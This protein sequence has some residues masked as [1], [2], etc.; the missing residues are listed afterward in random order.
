MIPNITRGDRFAGLVSYL[1]GKGRA[2]EHTDPRVIAGES[3]LFMHYAGRTL[4]AQDALDLGRDLEE[5]RRVTGTNVRRLKRTTSVDARTGVQVLEATY[6]DAHVWHCSLSLAAEEGQLSDEQWN[7]IASDFVDAMG[8]TSASGKADCRWVAVRHGLS[9]NGNDHVHIAVSLVR[10]DGTKANVHNDFRRAQDVSRELEVKYGLSITGDRANDLGARGVKPAAL[11]AAEARGADH[12]DAVP[13]AR[14]VR[15]AAAASHDEAE[16]VRRCRRTGLLVRPRFASGTTDVVVGYS[17]ALRPRRR[18]DAVVWHGGGKLGRDLTL[19]RLR[20]DWPDTLDTSAAAAAEWQAAYRG[21]P[22]FAPGRELQE[23]DPAMWDSY[24][25]QMRELRAQLRS[26][27]LD[28][29]NAWARVA[30]DTS[31]VLAAWS[32]RVEPTTGP[33]AIASAE[34]ARNAQLKAHA[35]TPRPPQLRSVAAAATLFTAAALKGDSLMAQALLIRELARAA[36]AVFDVV[37]ARG[38]ARRAQQMTDRVR[39]QL[40][41]VMAQLPSVDAAPVAAAEVPDTARPALNELHRFEQPA[42]PATGVGGGVDDSRRQPP[43][44]SPKAPP[45]LDR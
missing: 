39:A 16:F 12:V 21:D 36:Q 34:L 17:V 40:Q 13:L 35:V 28:D 4:D 23:P 8:F 42:P 18:E 33:L 45:E 27:P 2:N 6:V 9:K 26:I 29:R 15:A 37:Q 31:G 30:R 38:D 43:A 44:S 41:A 1:A 3:D 11:G 5:S 32:Q 19:P 25:E 22:P 10:T 14:A 24:L 7:A 20:E